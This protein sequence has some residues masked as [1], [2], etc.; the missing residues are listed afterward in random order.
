MDVQV[1]VV[2]DTNAYSANDVIGGL[3]TFSLTGSST[4]SGVLNSLKVCDNDNEGAAGAL[5]LFRPGSSNAAP[6]AALD[7]AAF[8]P[9]ITDLE[10]LIVVITLGTFTTVNSLKEQVVEDINKTFH[11]DNNIIYGY[12]VPSGTPTYAGTKRLTF[13]LGILTQ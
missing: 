6:T 8:A 4:G 7:N 2:P 11:V 13:E 9:T 5:W 12:F 1:T 3:L 10:N